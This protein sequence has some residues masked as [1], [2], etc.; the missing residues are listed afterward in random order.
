MY[1][2]FRKEKI[3]L[4]LKFVEF[5]K[6]KKDPKLK[7]ETTRKQRSKVCE[8]RCKHTIVTLIPR[9]PGFGTDRQ[10]I[11]ISFL[12]FSCLDHA[13]ATQEHTEQPT[14]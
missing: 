13:Q 10:P 6:K 2:R 4:A 7:H 3:D 12:D 11:L 8:T 5:T 1:K 9:W 14:T